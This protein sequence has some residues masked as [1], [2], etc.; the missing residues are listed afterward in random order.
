V[1]G[2]KTYVP[3]QA[4]LGPI[5]TG[6]YAGRTARLPVSRA[7]AADDFLGKLFYVIPWTGPDRIDIT[8]NLLP[9]GRPLEFQTYVGDEVRWVTRNVLRKKRIARERGTRDGEPVFMPGGIRARTDGCVRLSATWNGR[10]RS[11]QIELDRHARF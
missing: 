9:S 2:R 6:A 5:R 7:R 1:R 8:G 11:I 3:S 4:R 10:T